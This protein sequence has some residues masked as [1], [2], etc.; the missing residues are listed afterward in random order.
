M[1][2]RLLESK[3]D[4]KYPKFRRTLEVRESLLVGTTARWCELAGMHD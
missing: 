1:E 4:G 2:C 3:I